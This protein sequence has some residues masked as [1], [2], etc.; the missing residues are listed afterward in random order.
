MALTTV[1]IEARRM[2]GQAIAEQPGQIRKSQGTYRV[3]SQSHAGYYTVTPLEN[4]WNCTCP[5]FVQRGAE[6]CKHIFAVQFSLKLKETVQV[7]REKKEVVLEQFDATSCLFCKSPS[8]KK[9]GIR[10]NVS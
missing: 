7:E 6:T 4:G 2:K 3:E 8:L 10:H 9:F 1:Q 5:D